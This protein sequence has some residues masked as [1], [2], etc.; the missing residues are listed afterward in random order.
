MD[1]ENVPVTRLLISTEQDRAL[2]IRK[3]D[4]WHKKEDRHSTHAAETLFSEML[5]FPI[6]RSTK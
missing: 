1:Q 2:Q 6:G 4:S 5:R 3:N